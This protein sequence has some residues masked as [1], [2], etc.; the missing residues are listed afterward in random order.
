MHVF[1]S[2][3]RLPLVLDLRSIEFKSSFELNLPDYTDLDYNP[4]Y[5]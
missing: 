2:F 5:N 3:S 1:Y 4:D